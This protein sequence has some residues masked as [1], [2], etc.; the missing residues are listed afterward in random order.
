M[1]NSATKIDYVGPALATEARSNDDGSG[2]PWFVARVGR[3]YYLP[4]AG[5]EQDTMLDD[6]KAL[7]FEMVAQPNDPNGAPEPIIE[8][9]HFD[10][11]AAFANADAMRRYARILLEVADHADSILSGSH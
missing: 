11:H 8:Q 9:L 3:G 2:G 4:G 10:F 6:N 7:T 1:S 5:P